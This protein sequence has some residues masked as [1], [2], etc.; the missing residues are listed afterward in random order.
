MGAP[1]CFVD[2][3]PIKDRDIP[4]KRGDF[5]IKPRDFPIKMGMSFQ[6]AMF[7]FTRG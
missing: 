1:E 5:P 7:F 3:F 6:P 2:V 4:I